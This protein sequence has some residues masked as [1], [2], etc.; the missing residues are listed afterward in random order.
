M[1]L[2]RRPSRSADVAQAASRIEERPQRADMC[3][4][5]GPQQGRISRW[6]ETHDRPTMPAV[7]LKRHVAPRNKRGSGAAP[8]FCSDGASRGTRGSFAPRLIA[9]LPLSPYSRFQIMRIIVT[10][11]RVLQAA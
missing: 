4:D 1:N 10:G 3:V 5:H 6:R 2:L 8:N 9:R 11:A 7:A